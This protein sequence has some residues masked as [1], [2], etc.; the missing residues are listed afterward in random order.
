MDIHDLLTEMHNALFKE[1]DEREK[2]YLETDEIE[3]WITVYR[4]WLQ[5]GFGIAIEVIAKARERE[6][7]EHHSTVIN[8]TILS[9]EDPIRPSLP[10]GTGRGK[11][12][13]ENE[14]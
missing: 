14:E 3:E 9:I 4:P 6:Y 12:R 10:C 11:D 7:L 1:E 8:N 2:Q 5:R 13:K